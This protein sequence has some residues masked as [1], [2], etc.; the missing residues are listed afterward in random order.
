LPEIFFFRTP[1]ICPG[2]CYFLE[3]PYNMKDEVYTG[4]SQPSG[5]ISYLM[6]TER[7]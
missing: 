4:S 7:N 2:F 1:D 5:T 6:R 3:Q